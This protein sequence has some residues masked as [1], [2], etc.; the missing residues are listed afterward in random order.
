[1]SMEIGRSHILRPHRGEFSRENE[2]KESRNANSRVCNRI[3]DEVL[4]EGL[5]FIIRNKNTSTVVSLIIKIPLLSLNK[6]I[7]YVFYNSIYRVAMIV[8]VAQR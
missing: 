7:I 8:L 5:V 3:Y 1:M 2:Y 4:D 6:Y